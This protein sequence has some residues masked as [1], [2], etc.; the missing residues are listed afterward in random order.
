MDD[1]APANPL[2]A[3]TTF[4]I[5]ALMDMISWRRLPP[6]LAGEPWPCENPETAGSAPAAAVDA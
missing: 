5:S 3:F 4:A 2:I 1:T 6:V